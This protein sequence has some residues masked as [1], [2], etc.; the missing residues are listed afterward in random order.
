MNSITCEYVLVVVYHICT[1]L[2]LID[3]G[4]SILIKPNV[5]RVCFFC[6][7]YFCIHIA[8]SDNENFICILNKCDL[9][10]YFIIFF[11]ENNNIYVYF[12]VSVEEI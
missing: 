7:A 3:Q 11:N 1:T 9:H 10:K 6:L 4:T 5:I 2:I 12:F 8:A